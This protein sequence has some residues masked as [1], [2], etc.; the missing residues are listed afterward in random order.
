[1]IKANMINNGKVSY[2][3]LELVRQKESERPRYQESTLGDPS[4]PWRTSVVDLKQ[5][6]GFS[7]HTS[8]LSH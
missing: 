4:G 3:F 1:M 8:N 7:S 6:S 5:I 2:Y